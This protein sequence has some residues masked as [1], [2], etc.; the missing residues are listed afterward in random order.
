MMGD[1]F[2]SA[3]QNII[4]SFIAYEPGMQ[5]VLHKHQEKVLAVI[6]EGLALHFYF[7]IL[8]KGIYLS[9]SAPP[10]IHAQ[11]SGRPFTLARLLWTHDVQLLRKN[12]FLQMTG[13]IQFCNDLFKA[14]KEAAFDWQAYLSKISHPSIAAG[15]DYFTSQFKKFYMQSKTQFFADVEEYIHYEN[16]FLVR[17]EEMEAYFSEISTL[18]LAFSRL[19]A[20]V[21][22]LN[23]M[24]NSNES[25]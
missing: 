4:D 18:N 23:T 1:F 13:D 15:V 2:F 3:L 14:W 7:T 16:Q 5:P 9:A 10:T 21:K 22:R 12:P 25:S 11:I 20:R 6:V 17:K 8:E 24:I 19:N